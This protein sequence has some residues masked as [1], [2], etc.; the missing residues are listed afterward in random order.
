MEYL[1]KSVYLRGL[2]TNLQIHNNYI[3]LYITPK[4]YTGITWYRYIPFQKKNQNCHRNGID[5]LALNH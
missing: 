3:L 2:F 1:E 5:K 4:R